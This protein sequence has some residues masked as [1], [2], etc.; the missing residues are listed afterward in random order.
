MKRETKEIRLAAVV[1]R[2]LF[3]NTGAGGYN[4]HFPG[5]VCLYLQL[6]FITTVRD[7]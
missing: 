4:P 2:V 6:L 1:L 5:C 7:L 3:N